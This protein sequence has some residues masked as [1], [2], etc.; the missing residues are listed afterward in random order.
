MGNRVFVVTEIGA[1]KEEYLT[2]FE[3][4]TTEQLQICERLVFDKHGKQVN[5]VRPTD[6]LAMM[7]VERE[8]EARRRQVILA[9]GG[10]L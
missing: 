5:R 9:C 7:Q 6:V 3:D 8:L 2:P 1:E 10:A 4:A